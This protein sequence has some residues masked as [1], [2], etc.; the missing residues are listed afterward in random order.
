LNLKNELTVLE[1]V[2][3]DNLFDKY[4]M[5]NIH[6]I[7][8]MNMDKCFVGNLDN[9]IVADSF[10]VESFVDKIADNFDNIR[11][12]VGSRDC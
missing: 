3:L 11:C 2:E 9:K 6:K 12:F 5:V 8:V 10:V 1:L 4:C 7:V